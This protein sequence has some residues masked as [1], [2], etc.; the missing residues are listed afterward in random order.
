[1]RSR[2]YGNVVCFRMRLDKKSEHK[3]SGLDDDAAGYV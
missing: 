3:N 2:E 1:M